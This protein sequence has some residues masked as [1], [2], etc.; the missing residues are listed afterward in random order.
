[1]PNGLSR[2][3][4]ACF[5]ITVP[6]THA[7][8]A[9]AGISLPLPGMKTSTGLL[10][11]PTPPLVTAATR[12]EQVAFVATTGRMATLAFRRASAEPFCWREEGK[13]SLGWGRQQP[14][15]TEGGK[16]GR[17]VENCPLI[18]LLRC[19]ASRSPEEMQHQAI[20]GE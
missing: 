16:P 9:G 1:M 12:T 5:P 20:Y 13:K 3:R 11:G 6:C 14:V 10:K 4:K 8:R 2:A 17:F 15:P 19:F 18:K 7:T